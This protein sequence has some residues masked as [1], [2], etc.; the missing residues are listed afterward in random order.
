MLLKS[1]NLVIKK[2]I[3][4]NMSLRTI[5]KARPRRTIESQL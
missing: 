4:K 1:D 2:D 3:S 5:D